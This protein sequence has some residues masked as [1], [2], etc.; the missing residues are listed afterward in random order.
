[1]EAG[2]VL[3][4]YAPVSSSPQSS[5]GDSVSAPILQ[6][7]KQSSG[8]KGRELASMEPKYRSAHCQT[9]VFLPPSCGPFLFSVCT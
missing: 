7:G 5:D 2:Y 1:M 3:A 9:M 4:A 6:M 8:D